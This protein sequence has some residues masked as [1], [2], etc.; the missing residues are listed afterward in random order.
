MNV[1]GKSKWVHDLNLEG[2]GNFE[3]R[4]RNVLLVPV[5]SSE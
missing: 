2:D 3:D 4:V 1:D 5:N